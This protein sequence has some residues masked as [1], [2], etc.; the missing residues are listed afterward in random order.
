MVLAFTPRPI[1]HPFAPTKP[2]GPNSSHFS[3]VPPPTR[4]TRPSAELQSTYWIQGQL[5]FRCHNKNHSVS[6]SF[7]DYETIGQA[8]F[9][10]SGYLSLSIFLYL[11]C[12]YFF[13]VP[14]FFPTHVVTLMFWGAE[15]STDVIW[16]VLRDM[17]S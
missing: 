7:N 17:S 3:K 5:A 11:T 4:I 15:G 6:R 13:V 10:L 8:S 1:R 2:L 16:E 12:P 14:S 9:Y